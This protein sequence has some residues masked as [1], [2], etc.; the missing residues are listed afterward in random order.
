MVAERTWQEPETPK[1][2][3][4]VKWLRVS[5]GA[6]PLCALRLATKSDGQCTCARRT[7]D[8]VRSTCDEL[9]RRAW[10]KRS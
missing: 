1:F 2:L 5:A 6:S 7:V 4:L 8:G 10:V 9:A 3:D